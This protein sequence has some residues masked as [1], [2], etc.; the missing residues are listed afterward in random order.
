[1]VL[2]VSQSLMEK[3]ANTDRAGNREL[4]IPL[5]NADF[6]NQQS[7]EVEGRVTGGTRDQP[8]VLFINTGS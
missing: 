8:S 5:T 7:A 3:Q 4:H 6:K 2:P 1:M